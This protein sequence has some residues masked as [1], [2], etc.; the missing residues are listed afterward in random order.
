MSAAMTVLVIATAV[1]LTGLWVVHARRDLQRR[2]A[3]ASEWDT[4][5]DLDAGGLWT[6]GARC[7]RCAAGGAV[8]TREGDVLW[9]V[10]L[11]CGHRHRREHRG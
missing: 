6:S 2:R 11:R 8:L 10:C 7:L 4:D 5:G 1:A 3:R 9:H